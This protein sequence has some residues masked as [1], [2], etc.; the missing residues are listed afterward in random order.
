MREP[1]GMHPADLAEARR[2]M[3]EHQIRPWDVLDPRVT[4]VLSEVPR[5]E[6]VPERHRGHAFADVQIPI[7]HEQVMMEP[8]V[9]G[10]ML[11]ALDPQPGDHVLEIGTGS[12]FITACLTRLARAVNSVE[13]FP[14][15]QEQAA[16][17]LERGGYE[18]YRLF[19][20]EASRGWDDGQRYEAIAVTGSLPE[21]HEGFHE[22]LTVGG[23]L[24]VIVGSFPIMEALLITRTDEDAWRTQSLFETSVPALINAPRRSR[25]ML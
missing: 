11:Q 9:E 1:S 18:R 15:L 2:N 24:F 13:Y 21:L 14:A 12:G 19:T 20:G 10:R 25:F 16:E 23:R 5:E 7:G 8:R 4:E 22:S 6:F 17:R 3:I